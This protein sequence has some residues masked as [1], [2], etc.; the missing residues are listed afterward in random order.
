MALTPDE[1]LGGALA[2]I[3]VKLGGKDLVEKVIKEMP[4]KEANDAQ[5]GVALGEQMK[6][7]T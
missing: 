7:R 2:N 6:N 3:A 5:R 4:A 1:Q